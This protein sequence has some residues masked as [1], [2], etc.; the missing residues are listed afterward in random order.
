MQRTM[1]VTILPTISCALV[2]E[3]VKMA[4]PINIVIPPA[5]IMRLRPIFS[6]I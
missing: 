1:P 5:R 3:L 4:V 6:P 2:N